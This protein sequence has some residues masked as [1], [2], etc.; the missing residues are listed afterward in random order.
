MLEGGSNLMPEGEPE[1]DAVERAR[2]GCSSQ[3][4]MPH[5]SKG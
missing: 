1:M 2:T 4:R 5:K 3:K